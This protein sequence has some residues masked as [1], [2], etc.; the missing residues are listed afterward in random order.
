[1]SVSPTSTVTPE[2]AQAIVDALAKQFRLVLTSPPVADVGQTISA[3]VLPRV[4]SLDATELLQTM[5]N[6]GFTAKNVLFDAPQATT[7]PDPADPADFAGDTLATTHDFGLAGKQDVELAALPLT[8]TPPTITET[9]GMLGQLFG[10]VTPPAF[11]LSIRVDIAWSVYNKDGEELDAGKDFLALQGLS[12]VNASF[13]FK[14]PLQ[15]LRLNTLEE[16]GG[17]VFCIYADV[18]ITLQDK[19]A[20][21]PLGPI[22]VVALPLL[23]PT[24]VALFDEVN[25]EASFDSSVLI[26]VPAHSPFSSASALFKWVQ[27]LED[28]VGRLRGIGGTAAWLLG[29]DDLLSLPDHPRVRFVAT[30]GINELGSVRLKRRPWYQFWAGDVTFDDRVWSLFVFG[31]PGTRVDFFNDEFFKGGTASTQGNFGIQ[32]QTTDTFVAIRTLDTDDDVAPV[33]FPPGRAIFNPD[34]DRDQHGD[35][36]WHTDMSSVKFA[37]SVVEAG[38]ITP[39]PP[40]LQCAPRKR[41]PR[42][43]PT[44]PPVIR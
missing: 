18:R 36:L 25:F 37:S 21:A 16:P 12:D 28:V 32:L 15:E 7:L 2:Q 34:T 10:T 1:M 33:T 22:P 35:D 42:P 41:R 8:G 30:D 13:L 4:H 39:D 40:V 24:V 38:R 43:R 11:D 17:D 6:L 19:V 27:R 26:L 23:L 29:L 31:I 44:K 3:A 9:V 5:V 14:P 20:E